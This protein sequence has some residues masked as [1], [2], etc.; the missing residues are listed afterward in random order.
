MKTS[1]GFVFVLLMLAACIFEQPEKNFNSVPKNADP[2]FKSEACYSYDDFVFSALID[3]LWVYDHAKLKFRGGVLFDYQLSIDNQIIREFNGSDDGFE[4]DASDYSAGSYKLT[5]IQRARSGTKS[6]ADEAGVEYVEYTSDYI[7]VF[8]AELYDPK[9]TSIENV[10]GTVRI[11]WPRFQSGNFEGFTIYKY[12]GS[13][14]TAYRSFTLSDPSVHEFYDTTYV[15]G[16][17]RYKLSVQQGGN[18]LMSGEKQLEIVYNPRLTLS[19]VSTGRLKLTWKKP[20]FHN[21]IDHYELRSYN[22]SVLIDGNISGTVNS[23]EFSGQTAYGF[24]TSYSLRIV[25]KTPDGVLK[26]ADVT[27]VSSILTQGERLPGFR[28]IRFNK[29]DNTFYLSY[30]PTPVTGVLGFYKLDK[31]FNTLD[32]VVY[33]YDIYEST[34]PVNFYQSPNGQ[35]FY[36]LKA[37]E[38]QVRNANLLT[39]KTVYPISTFGIPVGSFESFYR[40]DYFAVSNNNMLLIRHGTGSLPTAYIINMQTMQKIFTL[41]NAAETHLSS[42]GKYFVNGNVIYK[43][44]GITYT[45]NFILP[46]TGIRYVQFLDDEPNKILLLTDNKAIIYDCSLHLQS[47]AWDCAPVSQPYAHLDQSKKILQYRSV[48][49]MMTIDLNSGENRTLTSL[50]FSEF[51]HVEGGVLFESSGFGVRNY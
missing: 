50:D 1:A 44:D 31:D 21:N 4:F 10:N 15:G 41:S 23:V 13:D 25:A 12:A 37:N 32:S 29:T 46:Y 35:Y 14:I 18:I 51:L 38:I 36:V 19:A 28:K 9:I 39:E 7:V 34:T 40:N 42:D 5:I 6:L 30:E 49:G 47:V 27:S 16:V 48:S 3:T 11:T 8:N 22:G 33:P 24:S 17:V 45:S 20:P 43:F 26:G 2:I